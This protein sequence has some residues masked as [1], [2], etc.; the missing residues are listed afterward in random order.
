MR[1]P[2]KG[3]DCISAT[4][5][6]KCPGHAVRALGDYLF[7]VWLLPEIVPYI[8]ELTITFWPTALAKIFRSPL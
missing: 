2:G 8:Q 1:V 6:P 5:V 3:D 7:V 4:S